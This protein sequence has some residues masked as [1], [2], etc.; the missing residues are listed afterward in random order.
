[1]AE[2]PEMF[3]ACAWGR[4]PTRI[5]TWQR[6]PSGSPLALAQVVGDTKRPPVAPISSQSLDAASLAE[7]LLVKPRAVKTAALLAGRKTDIFLP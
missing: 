2:A 4:V 5:S 7:D 1:M 6:H 3:F